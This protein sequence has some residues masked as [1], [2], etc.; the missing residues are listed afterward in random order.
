MT[1]FMCGML[2]FVNIS[3][4]NK[5]SKVKV[6][7]KQVLNKSIQNAYDFSSTLNQLFVK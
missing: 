1:T 4:K 2:L 3:V 5:Y 6:N 7:K